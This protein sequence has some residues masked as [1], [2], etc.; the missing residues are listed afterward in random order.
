MHPSDIDGDG[1]MDLV[2]GSFKDDSVK[3][4]ENDGSSTGPTFTARLVTS[5]AD[6]AQSVFAFDVDSD[7]D[8]DVLS[9]S[10]FDHRI[11]W[12]EPGPR[13]G[14]SMILQLECLAIDYV[15]KAIHLSRP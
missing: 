5:S 9:A 12:Y 6:G 1:D 13:E 3:W 15:R 14:A 8:V 4:Y 2:V 10:F 11:T 7:N